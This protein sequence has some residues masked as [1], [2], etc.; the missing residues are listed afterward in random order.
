MQA[1]KTLLGGLLAPFLLTA[2]FNANADEVVQV[3]LLDASC[4]RNESSYLEEDTTFSCYGY[5][6]YKGNIYSIFHNNLDVPYLEGDI[7]EIY[8]TD[9]ESNNV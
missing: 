7:V 5:F 2:C 8:L 9:L 4:I 1:F 6:Q 3:E